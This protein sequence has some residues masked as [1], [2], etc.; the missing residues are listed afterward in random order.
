MTDLIQAMKHNEE[1]VVGQRVEVRWTNC[2]NYY[3][4]EGTVAKINAKSVRVAIDEAQHGYEAGREISSPR[5]C[6][7]TMLRW[8]WSNCVLPT[9]EEKAALDMVE[10]KHPGKKVFLDNLG[11]ERV[12]SVY[13]TY[14]SDDPWLVF[15]IEDALAL[16]LE[17]VTA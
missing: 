9:E 7:D 12:V 15:S 8:S 1:L 5:C 17:G 4:A 3:R 11:E 16:A 10:A 6:F 2:G 13:E 14:P